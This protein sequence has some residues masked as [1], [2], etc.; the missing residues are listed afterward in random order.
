MIT[1][2]WQ[3]GFVNA[4]PDGFM[5]PYIGINGQWP[6]PPIVGNLG[7]T[8]KINVVNNLGNQSTS[9]HFHGLFQQGTNFEDGPVGVTQCPIPPGQSFVYQFRL[10]Q[11]GTYW[12]HAHI[13]G[14]YMYNLP[15]NS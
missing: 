9:L 6:N 3:I 12:W 11:T 2:N 1:Y 7:D 15:R 13:G 4:A 14:Q 5:R 8:I 10:N